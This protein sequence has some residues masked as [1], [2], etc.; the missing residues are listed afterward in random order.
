MYVGRF[1]IGGLICYP[2][3]E[4]YSK[5]CCL[6]LNVTYTLASY[7]FSHFHGKASI[8]I[9]ISFNP[10]YCILKDF[11]VKSFHAVILIFRTFSSSFIEIS[12]VFR[13]RN[14]PYLLIQALNFPSIST[15]I[16]LIPLLLSLYLLLIL[17][18]TL[19]SL[20][21][22]IRLLLLSFFP[23]LFWVWLIIICQ[24]R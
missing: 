5:L 11:S 13:H 14:W 23:L 8:V 3:H 21:F 24:W 4:E 2:G 9:L 16:T 18:F 17:W 6:C 15:A 7:L 22:L 12:T 1:Q 10:D 19:S 20:N